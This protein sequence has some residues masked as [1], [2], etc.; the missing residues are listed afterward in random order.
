MQEV[1]AFVTVQKQEK[2]DQQQ[3]P[4]GKETEMLNHKKQELKEEKKPGQHKRGHKKAMSQRGTQDYI[5]T[6]G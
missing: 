2:R 4:K 3:N 5:H 6:E 1:T